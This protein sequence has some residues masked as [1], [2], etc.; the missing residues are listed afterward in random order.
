MLKTFF[1]RIFELFGIEVHRRD[2]TI[3]EEE[4]NDLQTYRELFL[5]DSV[6]HKH[7]YNVGSGSFYHPYWTNLDYVSDWYQNVQVKVVHIDLMEMGP[8]PI[9]ANTAEVIYT[10]HTIEHIKDDAVQNLFNESYKAL[11]PGGFLRVT[12]GPD[13][14]LDFEALKRGDTHWFYWNKWYE[15]PGTYEKIFHKPATAVPMEERWLHHVASPLA[16]NDKSPSPV[17]INA[18]QI[19]KLINEKSKEE[20]LDYLTSLCEFNSERTGNHVSWWNYD[21][22]AFFMR[23]AGFVNVY[24]SGYGQSACP[25]LRNVKYFDNTHPQI[26]VY[27]E[28]IK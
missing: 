17:K 25:I 19:K 14:D 7:F 27:A 16:P 1:K 5:E 23:K 6:V 20:V 26:S 9:S 10:S 15:R 12:T 3:S 4:Q 2:K 18:E 24:K 13:A 28:A 8:L 22:I 21:K 11:K